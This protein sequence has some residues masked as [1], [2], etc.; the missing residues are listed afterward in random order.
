MCLERDV[1]KLAGKVCGRQEA[2]LGLS[3]SCHRVPTAGQPLSVSPPPP[4]PCPPLGEVVLLPRTHHRGCL[5]SL[6][7]G[8]LEPFMQPPKE[9]WSRGWLGSRPP[10]PPMHHVTHSPASVSLA[11]PGK[12]MEV[13]SAPPTPTDIPSS[14]HHSEIPKACGVIELQPLVKDQGQ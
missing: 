12:G 9:G 13:H 1:A 5:S 7:S 8:C 11:P 14:S 3:D 2:V 6:P 4:A 10:P